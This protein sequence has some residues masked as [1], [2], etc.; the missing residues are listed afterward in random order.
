M[1]KKSDQCTSLWSKWF[2]EPYHL[3][4]RQVQQKEKHLRLLQKQQVILTNEKEAQGFKEIIE[5][6]G[7]TAIIKH[8]ETATADAQISVIQSLIS[9]QVD[10]ICIAGNDEN[11][12]QAAL[13]DAMNEGIK[14]SCLDAKVNP[15]S[16]MTFVNQAGVKEIGEAL[17]DAVLDISGGEGQWAILS[18]T[19]QATNQNAWIDAMKEVMKDDKYSKLELVE[20]SYGDDEPQKSTDVTQALLQTYP[21]LKVICAPTNCRYCSSCKS[22]SG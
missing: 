21:D 22:S 2:L 17:M 6:E 16:R 11:A 13:E 7:G 8:P 5:A 15:A 19:S 10:A 12:L 4:L 14:V 18:A 1:N 9:Q 3:Y 20:V